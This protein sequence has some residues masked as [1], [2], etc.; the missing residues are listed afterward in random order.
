MH[1]SITLSI[2]PHLIPSYNFWRH[3]NNATGKESILLNT[4]NN[5]YLEGTNY[6]YSCK[7][8]FN[9]EHSFMFYNSNITNKGCYT[10]YK[11][12]LNN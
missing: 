7:H 10:N 11:L 6:N 12:L 2:K 4:A 8:K 5:N 9:A 1:Y 3:T